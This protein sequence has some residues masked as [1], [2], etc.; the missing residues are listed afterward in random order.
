MENIRFNELSQIVEFFRGSKKLGYGREGACYKIKNMSYKFYNSLYREIYG[1]K[2]YQKQLILFRDKIVNNIYFIRGLMF[3]DDKLIGS[4]T[5]YA[6]G[7]SCGKLWLYRSNLDKL[8]GALKT[9]KTDV[10][11]LSELGICVMDH[12]LSNVLYDGNVFSLIDVGDYCYSSDVIYMGD[13]VIVTDVDELYKENMRKIVSLLFEGI[14]SS[15]GIYDKFVFA[16]LQEVKSPYKDYLKD[17]DLMLEP[18]ETIIGIRNEIQEGIGRE[19][20]TFSSCRK[21][22]QRIMKMR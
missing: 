20:A 22:L 3:Y 11:H 9:L 12:D 2:E 19:I 16:Y 1:E 4:V 17:I 10:Y 7:N 18:D 15:Y 13:N 8:I 6:S 14:T 21:D 5:E